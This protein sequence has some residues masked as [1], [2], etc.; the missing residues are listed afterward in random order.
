MTKQIQVRIPKTGLST[1]KSTITVATSGFAGEEC[2][3]AT[4]SI[5]ARLG[6]VESDEPTPEMYETPEQNYETIDESGT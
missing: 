3:K 1:G 2:V 6:T 4:E 5:L